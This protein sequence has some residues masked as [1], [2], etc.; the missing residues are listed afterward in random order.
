MDIGLGIGRAVDDAGPDRLHPLPRHPQATGDIAE[1]AAVAPIRHQVPRRR[2]A[3]QHIRVQQDAV[4]D[5]IALVAFPARRPQ[6]PD[7][8]F[9]RGEGRRRQKIALQDEA[10]A[11][12]RGAV[13]GIDG[14]RQQKATESHGPICDK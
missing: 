5:R 10:V 13:G 8:R 14:C 9:Q 6:G 2:Q 11:A 12:E 1:Q 7:F 3:G 4:G